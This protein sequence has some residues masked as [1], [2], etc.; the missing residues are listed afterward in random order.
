MT[1]MRRRPSN[2]QECGSRTFVAGLTAFIVAGLVSCGVGDS[3]D[4]VDTIEVGTIT[5]DSVPPALERGLHQVFTATVKDPKGK[6]ITVPLVWRSTNERVATFEPDGRL[7]AR[8]TGVTNVFA[9]A[10]NVAST[11]VGVR[12]KWEGAAKLETFQWTAPAAATP[13]AVVSDSIRAFVTNIEKRPATGARVVFTVTGGGGSVSPATVTTSNAGVASTQWTLGPSPGSNT[14]TA[15]VVDDDSKPITWATPNEVTF[16]IRSFAALEVVEGNAQQGLVLDKLPIPPAVR[17]VD[18]LGKP[19]LGVPVTFTATKG[20]QVK[21]PVVSTG[22]DGIASPGEWILG[23]IPG[24]QTLEAKV[25]SAKLI[26][27]ATATG[28]PVRYSPSVLAAGGFATCAL[29]QDG[30]AS[31]WGEQPKVG[32]STAKN[33]PSPTPT[34]GGIAFKSLGAGPTH[35]CGVT[36]DSAAYCWGLNVVL[37]TFVNRLHAAAPTRIQGD[38]AWTQITTGSNHTCGLSKQTPYCW[39]DNQ[40]GQLGDRTVKSRADPQ[41]VYGGFQ[42]SAVSSGSYH[43]CGLA[44]AGSAFC[45]GLNSTGQLGDGTL[46]SRLAPTVVLGGLSFQTIGA[47]E[48][49]T[50]ALT[51]EGKVYCWGNIPGVNGQQTTPTTFTSSSVPVFTSLTVGGAHACALT[52]VGAAYCWGDN[53]AGQLGDSTTVRRTSPTAVAGGLKFSSLSAGY[54][55]TCGRTSEG[56][57]ACWGLNRAGELGDSTSA[58]R[59]T[60]RF[61]VIKVEP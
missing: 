6:V 45:W 14:L 7:L 22:A 3:T 19:R 13:G 48:G 11:P 23:D 32:D 49:W 39:G 46:T 26:L 51:T 57:V 50:C 24:D 41:P 33:R 38:V 34:K 60:P 12:V 56:S 21:T 28:T 47:G 10:L 53:S 61:I 17:L 58:F 16:T 18:S 52:G 25:E 5:V 44:T 40:A 31:C 35:F 9:S 4:P 59:L 37:D 36:A 55:H 15:T 1:F 43:T 27:H 20:G 8:D 30:L 2:R 29:G 54:A 42:F